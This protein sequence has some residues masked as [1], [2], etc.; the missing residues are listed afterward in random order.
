M[1][2]QAD[3]STEL[4]TDP[5]SRNVNQSRCNSGYCP[6][7]MML[8]I[9]CPRESAIEAGEWEIFQGEPLPNLV[10]G[11]TVMDQSASSPYAGMDHE[12]EGLSLFAE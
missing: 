4:Q 11:S 9:F 3:L 6:M 5:G 7:G 8:M 10:T 1:E 12:E 2:E